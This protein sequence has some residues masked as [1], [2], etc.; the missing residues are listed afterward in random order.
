MNEKSAKN[1][2]V[3]QAVKFALFSASA[4]IIQVVTFTLLNELL[5]RTESS[6]AIAQW[7]FNSEYSLI[8]FSFSLGLFLFK[9]KPSHW[10]TGRDSNPRPLVPKTSALIR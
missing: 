7:F 1:S 3:I 2:N 5:P 9:K 10:Y 4:G 8:L 6:N